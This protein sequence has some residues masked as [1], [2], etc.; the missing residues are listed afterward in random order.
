MA[1]ELN[2][3]W[4]KWRGKNALNPSCAISPTHVNSD[5]A[6]HGHTQGSCAAFLCHILTAA[7]QGCSSE[8]KHWYRCSFYPS[9]AAISHKVAFIFCGREMKGNCLALAFTIQEAN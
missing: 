4:K 5:P 7:L 8:M 9:S 2:E 6:W 1:L 3:M